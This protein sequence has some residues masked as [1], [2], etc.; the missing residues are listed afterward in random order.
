M[1]AAPIAEIIIKR[2]SPDC[3]SV[4]LEAAGRIVCTSRAFDFAPARDEAQRRV[5]AWAER[6]GYQVITGKE[7]QRRVG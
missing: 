7:G 1:A 3:L 5:E 6:N 2:T 4:R